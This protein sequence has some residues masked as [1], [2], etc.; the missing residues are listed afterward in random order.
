MELKQTRGNSSS[1]KR[2]LPIR[3]LSKAVHWRDLFSQLCTSKAD[4]GTALEADVS[5]YR[6]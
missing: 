5:S 2:I 1:R 4:P 6:K 3:R